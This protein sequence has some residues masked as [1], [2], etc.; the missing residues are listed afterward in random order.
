MTGTY[1][2]K[3]Y[4]IRTPDCLQPNRSQIL[5]RVGILSTLKLWLQSQ[6]SQNSQ[7]SGAAFTWSNIFIQHQH[8]Q[9]SK[10]I[11]INQ[12]TWWDARLRPVPTNPSTRTTPTSLPKACTLATVVCCKPDWLRSLPEHL[13]GTTRTHKNRRARRSAL[14]DDSADAGSYA[15][16]RLKPKR[17]GNLGIFLKTI[18]ILSRLFVSGT[19]KKNFRWKYDYGTEIQYYKQHFTRRSSPQQVWTDKRPLSFEC[20]GWGLEQAYPQLNCVYVRT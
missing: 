5:T 1:L 7:R 14:V 8:A 10:W 19:H 2:E 11:Q 18:M 16:S 9:R 15:C 3:R 20:T 12:C 4:G 13:G 17:K 6:R